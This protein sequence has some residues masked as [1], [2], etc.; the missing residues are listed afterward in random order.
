MLKSWKRISRANQR[1][2]SEGSATKSL[3]FRCATLISN[4]KSPILQVPGSERKNHGEEKR[5]F[6]YNSEKIT[7][8][9]ASISHAKVS[10]FC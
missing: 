1:D 9:I 2:R 6:H 7:I 8:V 3:R 10:V 4:R 5:G